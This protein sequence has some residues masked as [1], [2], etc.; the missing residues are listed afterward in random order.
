MYWQLFHNYSTD[1]IRLHLMAEKGDVPDTV[2][3]QSLGCV[4]QE[5]RRALEPK[6][7]DTLKFT[8]YSNITQIH[9]EVP[10][11]ETGM[12]IVLMNAKGAPH[13]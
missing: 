7:P 8:A 1:P 4:E 11:I 3:A 6:L 10:D 5:V 13:G 2:I 9:V 12:A